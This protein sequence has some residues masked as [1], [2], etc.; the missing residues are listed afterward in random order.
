M[1][2]I[3]ALWPTNALRIQLFAKYCEKQQFEAASANSENSWDGVLITFWVVNCIGNGINL[4][5]SNMK[6]V[7]MSLKTNCTIY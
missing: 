3:K 5:R 1:S 2:H 6:F 7:S 4:W